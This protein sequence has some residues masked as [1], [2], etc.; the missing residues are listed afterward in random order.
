M[1]TREADGAGK[2]QRD[3]SP[4]AFATRSAAPMATP[5]RSHAS[6]LWPPMREAHYAEVIAE[7]TDP[8]EQ[9]LW[10]YAAELCNRQT[11]LTVSR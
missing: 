9:L 11:G 5:C 10:P 3:P 2:V 1:Q 7:H 4:A 6:V 8:R